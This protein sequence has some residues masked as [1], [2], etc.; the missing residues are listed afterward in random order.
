MLRNLKK[1]RNNFHITFRTLDNFWVC[2]CG[3]Q[4]P[5]RVTLDLHLR[6]C[7]LASEYFRSLIPPVEIDKVSGFK[8]LEV[9]E[10]MDANAG[11]EEIKE[12]KN[13]IQ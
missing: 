10:N 6:D 11:S 3:F 8:E 2:G 5:D 1:L 4:T 13:G 7:D 9:V 12:N